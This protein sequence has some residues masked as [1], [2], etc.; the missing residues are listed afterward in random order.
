MVLTKNPLLADRQAYLDELEFR[1]MPD[2][3][4]GSTA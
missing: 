4:S 2:E 3:T 1:V